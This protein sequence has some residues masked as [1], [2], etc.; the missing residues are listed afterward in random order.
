MVFKSSKDFRI[1]D[2]KYG[3]LLFTT[4]G[5]DYRLANCSTGQI[6]PAVFV[7]KVLLEHSLIYFGLSW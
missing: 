4:N 3:P 5:I 6:R 7:N 1:I 2:K